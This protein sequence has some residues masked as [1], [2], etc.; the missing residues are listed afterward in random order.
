MSDRT[1]AGLRLRDRRRRLGGLRAA[2]RG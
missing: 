1:E 2:R